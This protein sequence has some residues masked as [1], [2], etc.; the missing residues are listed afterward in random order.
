MCESLVEKEQ[1]VEK[2]FDKLLMDLSSVEK[3]NYKSVNTE[4]EMMKLQIKKIRETMT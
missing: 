2:C 1:S 3:R 4:I